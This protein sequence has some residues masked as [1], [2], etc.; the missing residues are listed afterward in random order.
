MLSYKFN[1]QCI[2]QGLDPKAVNMPVI[3]GHSGVTIIPL[4]SQCTPAV[5]FPKD[6]LEALTVRIQVCSTLIKM[7]ISIFPTSYCSFTK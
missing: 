4:M 7:F 6:Q 1:E 2:L 3:G 5:S